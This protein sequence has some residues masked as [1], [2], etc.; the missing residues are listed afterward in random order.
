MNM[1]TDECELKLALGAIATF[2][3]QKVI[4]RVSQQIKSKR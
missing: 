4:L 2:R 3:S 1:K